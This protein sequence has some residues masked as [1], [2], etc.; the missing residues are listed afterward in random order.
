MPVAGA[1]KNYHT[2]FLFEVQI[3]G[4]KSVEFES[5]DGLD[6]ELGR[7]IKRE[8]GSVI[9]VSL[10]GMVK[11]RTLTLKRGQTGDKDLFIWM[12]TVVVQTAAGIGSDVI[13]LADGKYRRN[14]DIVQ[15]DRD[16]SIM[17]RWRVSGAWPMKYTGGSWDNTK[18]EVVMEEIQLSYDFFDPIDV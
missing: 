10:P 16:G 9:P 11:E 7:I 1:A 17:L 13:G 8:G 3:D 6:I 4:M 12:S 18:E 5:C 2:T 14:L 15:K